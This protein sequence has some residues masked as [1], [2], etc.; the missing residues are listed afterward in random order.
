MASGKK[1]PTVITLTS[2]RDCEAAAQAG[3]HWRQLEWQEL[4]ILQ[5]FPED[6]FFCGSPSRITKMI[7]Q[8]VQIDTGRAILA[9][10]VRSLS[11][12]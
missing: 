6:Y 2:R 5:G 8:A 4:A 7:A 12:G 10:F 11:K 3:E 1:S 9:N